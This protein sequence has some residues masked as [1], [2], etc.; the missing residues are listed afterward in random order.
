MILPLAASRSK[1][2]FFREYFMSLRV[3]E[4]AI[5]RPLEVAE[6]MKYLRIDN[7]EEEYLIGLCIDSATELVEYFTGKTMIEKTYRLVCG[8]DEISRNTM[9]STCVNLPRP[10]FLRLQGE[11]KIIGK[12]Y[13]RSLTNYFV[14]EGKTKTTLCSTAN[15]RNEEYL[16]IDYVCGYGSR[17]EDVPA[18]MRQA[19]LMIVAEMFENRRGKTD[20]ASPPTI[21]DKAQE[22]LRPFCIREIH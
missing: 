21:S 17:P 14:Q 18:V 1:R 12:T 13:H 5:C 2:L 10:P 3:L 11:P 15:L 8:I 4:P 20:N 22:I 9:F 19:M 7:Q 6:V 16:Q